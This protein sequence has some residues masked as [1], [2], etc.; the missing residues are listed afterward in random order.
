MSMS[1]HTRISTAACWIKALNHLLLL[2]I[3][4][5]P[6]VVVS[7]G[8]PLLATPTSVVS[9]NGILDTIITLEEA[10]HSL[11]SDAEASTNNPEITSRLF[12]ATFPGPTLRLK[13][14]DILRVEF[15]N[16][17]E[18]QGLA[19]SYIHNQF[20]APDESNLHFHGLHISG[21]LPSDDVTHVVK[22]GQRYTYETT[23]PD[24]HMGGTHWMHPHRHGSSSLQTGGGAVSA[25][26]VEDPPNTLP[27]QIEDANE[28]LFLAHLLDVEELHQVVDAS[29][30]GLFQFAVNGNINFPETSVLVN[31]QINPIVSIV[32]GEWVR[33]RVIWASWLEGNLN[34]S[35]D[36]CE[37][38]LL[39][40]DGIYIRDFPRL[41]ETAPIVPG[42]R[43]DIMI[44]C[45]AAS[46]TYH[47]MGMT[48][49][50]SLAKIQTANDVAVQT[51]SLESWSPSYPAYLTDLRSS[52]PTPG[53]ACTTEFNRRA[54]NGIPFPSDKES[55][56]HTTYLGATVDRNIESR[57]HPYHQHIYPFQLISGLNTFGGDN[58]Y[59]QIGDWH[60]TYTGS[61]L[62]RFSPTEFPGKMMVHCHRLNH[63]DEGMMAIEY[64]A[65][66]SGACTCTE[67]ESVGLGND[68]IIGIA[69]GIGVVVVAISAYFVWYRK[70][71]VVQ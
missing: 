3:N 67:S 65:I 43:A 22:P 59:N 34:I 5:Q 49:S 48:G 58:G 27:K 53:C 42:G 24:E 35:V 69:A 7:A 60:D 39:A 33:F 45:P 54:V 57:G 44:R 66:D 20:S 21:E 14:G 61:G 2:L 50:T 51:E 55:Y 41:I 37:M 28:V 62:I 1:I 16:K 23:L 19:T 13:P 64:V 38:H 32:A 4:A 12:N 40:K 68:A 9:S 15:Q 56:L 18:D 25:V 63:E 26:I 70:R 47:I 46:S 36:G 10:T 8:S 29:N 30:D 17:L 31:G 11:V 6:N 52:T 71:K